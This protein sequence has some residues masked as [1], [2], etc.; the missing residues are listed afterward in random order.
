VSWFVWGCY[1]SE[2]MTPWLTVP[3]AD[4]E[5]HMNAEGVEQLAPLRDLFAAALAKTRPA[6]VAILGVA[7]GNGLDAIDTALTLRIVGV[8]VHPEYLQAVGQRYAELP[9][10]ELHQADLATDSLQIAPVAHVHVA[11]VFEHAGMERCL[12][13][14]L[15]VVAPEGWLSVVLQLPSSSEHGVSPTGYASLQAL[16]PHFQFVEP[17]ALTRELT[18]MGFS[19]E[20]E[21]QHALP[22]GKAFWQGIYRR[23]R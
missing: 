14:A 18:S 3:L 19:L 21:Q 6:S 11:L 2:L 23:T 12:K 22:A 9:G 5:G 10:L 13:N 16:K 20:T 8:D 1:D 17:A 7:G 15:A 4:Y